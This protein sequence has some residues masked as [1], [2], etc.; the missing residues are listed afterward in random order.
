VTSDDHGLMKTDYQHAATDLRLDSAASLAWQA[1]QDADTR[2]Y[3]E[4]LETVSRF[5]EQLLAQAAQG[6]RWALRRRGE[7]WF[8][9]RMRSADDEL[10]VVTVRSAIADEPRVVFDPNELAA[11]RGV[12]LAL[13]WVSPSPDGRVL[14]VGVQA[15]G[16]ETVEVALLDVPTGASL[17]DNIPWNVS[18]PVSWLPDSSGFWC[19]AREIIDGALAMP[20][21]TL[22]L[23]APT[24][25]DP[26]PLPSGLLFPRPRVSRDGRHI[27]IETGNSLNRIDYVISGDGRVSPLL[28]DVPG[29]ASGRFHGDDL[30]AIVTGDAPRGRLVRI[31][32]ATASDQGTWTMLLPES[33]DVLQWI[34]LGKEFLAVGYLRDA[35][36]RLRILA[37]DGS[38]ARDVA[39]PGQ[40]AVGVTS[41]A[42]SHTSFAMFEA[43]DDELSFVYSDFA[44][45]PAVYRY[46]V[47]ED[48]LEVV[49]PPA[50]VID[51]LTVTLVEGVAKDGTRVPAHVVHRTD[52]DLTRAHPTLITGYGGFSLAMV[53]SYLGAYAPWVMGG[54][55]FVLS[56]LRGGGEYGL[57]WWRNGSRANKQHTYDD[58]YAVAE[59]L[60][61]LGI[62]APESLA[63]YGASNG[64]LLAGAAVAQR[65]ELWAVV[66]PDV[67]LLDLLRMHEDPF[68]YEMGKREYGDAQV[69]EEREWL[70]ACSPLEHLSSNSHP[71]T[72]VIAGAN[73]PRCPAWHSRVFVDRLRRADTG[74][75]PMHLR[76]HAEQGHGAAG[77][78]ATARR[79]AEWLGFC[80]EH[81]GLIPTE[82]EKL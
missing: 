27:A 79:T 44:T 54:G 13:Q 81:T 42:V 22:R 68:L 24:A 74:H 5:E 33:D 39:L 40:G 64:G 41:T 11:E 31:P 57:D 28:R 16:T 48:E 1:A 14:A 50:A 9:L 65:P 21:Y 61:A 4:G 78:M 47:T 72:L 38:E 45:S 73:D 32:V 3:L 2:A 62:A 23:G 15:A 12:P 77:A 59:H 6:R 26:V 56:H 10:P 17:P 60:I 35:T 43:G 55:V 76:V 82:E 49:D 37:I 71:A 46:A 70:R 75:Q 58:L 19:A 20:L 34:E 30:F 36:A 8:Q 67:P 53:P 52:L 7:R 63:L 25:S 80:A 69:P 66:V 29:G 51:G 18:F